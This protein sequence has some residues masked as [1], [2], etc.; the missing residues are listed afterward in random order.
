MVKE[1]CVVENIR[2][3]RGLIP[4][5][6]DQFVKTRNGVIDPSSGF[7]N[8]VETP[9]VLPVSYGVTRINVIKSGLDP[10]RTMFFVR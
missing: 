4:T 8:V 6:I 10:H 1:W 5:A 9:S 7:T 2:R 3:R